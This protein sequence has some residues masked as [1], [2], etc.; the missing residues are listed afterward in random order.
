MRLRDLA[1]PRID[2]KILA[3]SDN[4]RPPARAKIQCSPAEQAISQQR[5]GIRHTQA[6]E[7]RALT[8]ELRR[9][10]RRK[11]R[12]SAPNSNIPRNSKTCTVLGRLQRNV[13]PAMCLPLRQLRGSG[14]ADR[15]QGSKVY[16]MVGRAMRGTL[17]RTPQ[18]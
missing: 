12:R 6:P 1:Q 15:L 17:L 10:G 13:S 18:S 5:H 3:G 7:V 16:L 2:P 8:P 4:W 14:L 9:P 11:R